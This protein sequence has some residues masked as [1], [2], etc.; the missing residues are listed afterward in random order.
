MPRLP[1]RLL[2]AALPLALSLSV[3]AADT[4]LTTVSE[5]SGFLKTGRYDE[6]GALCDAFV[7]AYP[8]AVR[9]LSFGTSPEGRPMKALVA[10]TSGALTADQARRRGLPVVLIQGGIHAGEIDGKDAGFLAL[11]E[12]LEG[13]AAA[14]ALDKLVWVFV[15]VFSVDGHERF[16]AWNR[17]NQRGPEEMGWRTTAQNY[18][19]NRD[20]AKADTP[21]MQAMLRLIEEWDPLVT[22]DL[23]ATNGAQF[24][25]D[26]S[27]QVEPV[28]AGDAGLRAAGTALRDGTIAD[29]ARQGS[30]PLPFYPSFVT[31]DDP[32]S[33]FEDGVPPP[34]FS[35]GYFLL[36]NRI[37]MLV[38]THS[39]KEYPVRVRITRNTIISVLERTAQ[40]GGHW[41]QA[42][43]SADAT[44][45]ALAGQ[46]APLTWAASPRART[47]DFRGYAYT[48][49]PSEVSGALM[50][51][52]DETTP[53]IW[54]VPLRDDIQPAIS[55]TAPGAGYI[56]PAAHAAWVG[57]KLKLHGIQFRRTAAQTGTAVETYRASKTDF[58]KQSVEG[59][60]RLSVEGA[61]SRER[62][63]IGNGSLFV[64]IA[65]P[66]AR[67]AMALLEPAA[68]DSLLAWGGFNNAFE[69]KEYME[70]YVAEQ[71]A[72]Q[73][74][75]DPAVKAAFEQRLRD[76]QAFAGD[77]A[78]RLQFF[79]Q[80]HRSWDE[81]YNL[82]PVMRTDVAPR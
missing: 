77:P 35:H 76:D 14:G 33:G 65:Q 59:R 28:H 31:Y 48:R 5:R 41:L 25:H 70:D 4:A 61:W 9:C 46:P 58:A 71:V 53:Q 79:Y 62:R 32:A 66:K 74:L 42:A 3:A 52:Y 68:P 18:N 47:I 34:R 19:L 29:L 38:E 55:V 15:P 49:T 57:E 44:A 20:Y 7:K 54:Q 82:Y 30:L 81:R 50:T 73:M 60:Q 39:W 69:A 17:P 27:I 40:N 43:H 11:R 78:A 16:G 13:K 51:R 45:A 6:V 1:F 64:P 56:V 26:I 8:K 24:E 10:S 22:V 36:R 37:G 2:F 67:L 21:E 80:R 12:V 72:R 23:H 75:E 63:D